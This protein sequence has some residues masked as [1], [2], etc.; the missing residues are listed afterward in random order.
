MDDPGHE[1]TLLDPLDPGLQ[2]AIVDRQPVAGPRG[3][4]RLGKATLDRK[5]GVLPAHAAQFARHHHCD[6]FVALGVL[7]VAQGGEAASAHLGSA[8]VHED[9]HAMAG[10]LARGMNVLDHA[11]PFVGIVM[12]AINAHRLDALF[13]QGEHEAAV[14]R[15]GRGTRHEQ[16]GDPVA[17]GLSKQGAA[18]G[19]KFALAGEK[20][21]IVRDIASGAS[22]E[23]GQRAGDGV[24]GWQHAAFQPSEGGQPERHQVALYCAQVVK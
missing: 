16:G 19:E 7:V 2:L 12:S 5:I 3:V 24:Q 10:A 11:R 8:E 14:V 13:G 6:Q 4:D 15:R 23:P 22:P 20:C 21:G 9:A 17:C 1:E 18:A